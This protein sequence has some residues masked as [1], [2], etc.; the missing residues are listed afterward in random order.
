MIYIRKAKT[1][2]QKHFI[3]I[4]RCSFTSTTINEN[5]NKQTKW[6][7]DECKIRF[8]C[9]A[10]QYYVWFMLFIHSYFIRSDEIDTKQLCTIELSDF[11]LDCIELRKTD[12]LLLAS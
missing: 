7:M 8:F 4:G 5:Q 9:T 2:K 11:Y 1:E 10:P 12:A 3:L 6:Q